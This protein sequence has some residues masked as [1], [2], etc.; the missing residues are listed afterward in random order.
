ALALSADCIAGSFAAISFAA[1][2]SEQ[3]VGVRCIAVS[4]LG[5]GQP[6]A[7]SVSGPAARITDATVVEVVRALRQAAEELAVLAAERGVADSGA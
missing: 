3:E 4:V 2:D 7:V 5:L 1:D 6:A